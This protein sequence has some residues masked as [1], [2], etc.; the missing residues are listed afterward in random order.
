MLNKKTIFYDLNHSRSQRGA[1]TILL[2]FFVMN[3][4]LL[5]SLA[6]ASIAI[7]NIKML[8]GIADPVLAFYAA[9]AAAEKC[10]YELRVLADGSGCGAD[11]GSTSASLYGG[12]VIPVATRA[13]NIITSVGKF[14]ET[15]RKV[16]VS[17]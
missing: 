6:A 2:A 14:K 4:L 12:T 7:L 10:L 11:P 1:T 5:I 8:E 13:G 9:D 16:E 15:Q 3:V 17:F